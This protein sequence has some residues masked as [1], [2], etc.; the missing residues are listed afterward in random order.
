MKILLICGNGVSSGML[1]IKI[2]KAAIK[3]GY[4][5]I[6]VEAVNR[7]L[8]K[9]KVSEADIVLF[10][11]QLKFQEVYM[12]EICESNKKPYAFIDSI[13]YGNLDG[14][15]TFEFALKKISEYKKK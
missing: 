6:Q 2:K 5:D 14:I 9:E 10:G 15:K 4:L 12:R 13:M 11:P 7:F 1:G 8:T 3:L